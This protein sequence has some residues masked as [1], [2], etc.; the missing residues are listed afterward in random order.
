MKKRFTIALCGL[1]FLVCAVY[2]F[3]RH[4]DAPLV[5][6]PL[7]STVRSVEFSPDGRMV[8]ACTKSGVAL[9]STADW[10]QKRFLPGHTD[11]VYWMP[12]HTTVITWGSYVI[13][14]GSPRFQVLNDLAR[15][16]VSTGAQVYKRSFPL[17]SIVAISHDANLLAFSSSRT[18]IF[19]DSAT[20]LSTRTLFP[21][22][23]FEPQFSP[24]GRYFASVAAGL[25][26]TNPIRI[27][28]LRTWQEVSRRQL[29]QA[30][31]LCYS[32]DGKMLATGTN[33]TITLWDTATWQVVR[34]MPAHFKYLFRLRFSSD[35]TRLAGGGRFER[36]YPQ[37][38]GPD[39]FWTLWDPNTG[40]H[41]AD[42]HHSYFWEFVPKSLLAY[43]ADN[44]ISYWDEKDGEQLWSSSGRVRN[45]NNLETVTCGSLSPDHKLIVT[46]TTFNGY[47]TL[48]GREELPLGV[49][50]PA[51]VIQ[52]WNAPTPQ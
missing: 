6:I 49:K 44:N 3:Y 8:A 29:I 30:S 9:Y 1:G 37:T 19:I 38:K 13:H 12:D 25:N 50:A 31:C 35:G 2:A 11:F 52:V 21:L 18:V 41:I 15:W 22:N 4:K 43:T 39:F 24:D 45:S 14:Y 42:I 16:N 51:S 17:G 32:P 20:G 7:N 5:T 48:L 10:K 28:D 34:T 33:T 23:A 27:W 46:A 36:D 40:E 26:K 47:D